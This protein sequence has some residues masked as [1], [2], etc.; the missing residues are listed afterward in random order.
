M[1][2]AVVGPI[3]AAYLAPPTAAT[4]VLFGDS[5]AYHFASAANDSFSAPAISLGLASWPP[6]GHPV[7]G[8]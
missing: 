7:G 2:A 6:L 4:P 8:E 5:A 3:V 1:I